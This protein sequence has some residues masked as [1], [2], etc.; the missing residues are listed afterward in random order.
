[1]DLL[2]FNIKLYKVIL[3]HILMKINHFAQELNYQAYPTNYVKT[4]NSFI[5]NIL[6]SGLISGI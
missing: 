5:A 1:M 4:F 2:L 3:T 6:K